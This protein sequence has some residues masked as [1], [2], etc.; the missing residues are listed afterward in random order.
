MTTSSSDVPRAPRHAAGTP[1]RGNALVIS[2]GLLA[3]IAVAV[4]VS[5]DEALS[6]HGETFRRNH[7]NASLAAVDA[8]LSKREGM[9]IQDAED[10]RLRTWT[11]GVA[12]DTNEALPECRNNFG[13]D[14]VGQCAVLWKIEP[15]RSPDNS[16]ADNSGTTIPFVQNPSPLRTYVA[17]APEVINDFSFFYRISAEA[18]V[19]PNDDGALPLGR[20]QGERML[21]ITGEPLF[22]Y[23]IFYAKDGVK[24]DLELSHGFSLNVRGGVYSNGAIYIGGGTSLTWDSLAPGNQPT[25]LGPDTTGRTVRVVGV[26]GI[27]RLSK[28][29]MYSAFNFL[30]KM[31]GSNPGFS[32]A[33]AYD[34]AIT[35]PERSDPPGLLGPPATVAEATLDGNHINPYRVRNQSR[36]YTRSGVSNRRFINN[37]EITSDI[38]GGAIGNDSRDLHRDADETWSATSLATWNRRALTRVTNARKQSLPESMRGRPLEPQ[39]LVYGTD[40]GVGATDDPTDDHDE[41]LEATPMFVNAATGQRVPFSLAGPVPHIEVPGTYLTNAMGDRNAHFVRKSAPFNGWQ[42]RQLGDLATAAPAATQ[43]GLIIRERPVPDFSY[44]MS[45][46]VTDLSPANETHRAYVP[47]AYGKHK[48]PYLW[49]FTPMFV[50]DRGTT[51]AT[52]NAVLADVNNSGADGSEAVTNQEYFFGGHVRVRCANNATA[53]GSSPSPHDQDGYHRTNMRVIHLKAPV[54]P[55]PAS[56]DYPSVRNLGAASAYFAK[57]DFVAVQTRISSI[58]GG[59]PNP[60][61]RGRKAG[62]MIMPLDATTLGQ[63]GIHEYDK[64]L[65]S[66]RPYAAIFYSPERGFFTQRRFEHSRVGDVSDYFTNTFDT[67]DPSNDGFAW[68]PAATVYR[69]SPIDTKYDGGIEDPFGRSGSPPGSVTIDTGE[70]VYTFRTGGYTRLI[71]QRARQRRQAAEFNVTLS[72]AAPGSFVPSDATANP[73][74]SIGFYMLGWDQ[75]SAAAPEMHWARI[76]GYIS[77]TTVKVR[78]EKNPAEAYTYGPT[79]AASYTRP[80]DA[81]TVVKWERDPWGNLVQSGQWAAAVAAA[82]GDEQRV[83]DAIRDTEVPLSTPLGYYDVDLNQPPE[84]APSVVWPTLSGFTSSE[85]P[86]IGVSPTDPDAKTFVVPRS[87]QVDVNSYIS[88]RGA[89]YAPAPI[90]TADYPS[91]CDTPL[92][93][94]TNVPQVLPYLPV[95]ATIY[96]ET[97]S[98]RPDLYVGVGSGD[99]TAP[100]FATPTSTSVVGDPWED[101][102]IARWSSGATYNPDDTI[103]C[104]SR[105]FTCTAAH[106]ADAARRPGTGLTW[107]TAWQ[108]AGLWLRIEKITDGSHQYLRFL[109]YA[110][111][112]STPTAAQFIEMTDGQ[113]NLSRA[114]VTGWES[115]WVVGLASQSGQADWPMSATYSNI[116]IETALPAPL[117]VIDCID[118]E[119]RVDLAKPNEWARYMA[120]QYQVFWGTREITEHFFNYKQ[121]EAPEERLVTEGWMYNTREFWSQPRWW[122]QTDRDPLTGNPVPRAQW[123]EKETG[124]AVAVDRTTNRNNTYWRRMMARS[125]FLDVNLEKV[126]QYMQATTVAQATADSWGWGTPAMDPV[127]WNVPL[128]STF[129]GLIYVARAN[130]Y[131]W[132]PVPVNTGVVPVIAGQHPLQAV[133]NPFNP[134][135]PNIANTALCNSTSLSSTTNSD[136]VFSLGSGGPLGNAITGNAHALPIRPFDFHHGVMISNASRL[137][138]GGSAVWNNSRLTIVTPNQLYLNGDINSVMANDGSGPRV[139]P[140]AVM[141]DTVTLLSNSWSMAAFQ[142]DGLRLTDGGIDWGFGRG[143]LGG[144]FAELGWN[145]PNY[146]ASPTRYNTCIV[147]NNQPT[148]RDRVRMG[149]GASVVNALQLLESWD[150]RPLDYLGSLVVLD[151]ARYT[152]SF[153]LEQEKWAGR[154]ALGV[155]GWNADFAEFNGG[156]AFAAADRDWQGPL[157]RV[158]T[159]PTRNLSFNN[160]LLLQAGTP[161]FAPFSFTV[162]GIASWSRPIQ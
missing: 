6:V 48:R 63:A 55:I 24:G 85:I 1:R 151:T 138:W 105:L 103:Q 82:G 112:A 133:Q 162:N 78:W 68:P 9:L 40:A 128:A 141:G 124:L 120:S 19:Q 33:S 111:L 30:G 75:P 157:P 32:L 57:D 137:F 46:T 79:A 114:R 56:A 150:N 88:Q 149:E 72:D 148:T 123:I 156:A 146:R 144:C 160:D 116:R 18:R 104:D 110:G 39:A 115:D 20:A 44:I 36:L 153:L 66:R 16:A 49:P 139:V 87:V 62:L 21:S 100:T 145:N 99:F 92:A 107:M 41:H 28:P 86:N 154:G 35:P 3:L 80:G 91:S 108:P 27:F 70:G 113:G 76:I 143:T 12:T 15:V 126:Q 60:G 5:T 102:P 131:P 43:A 64:G 95:R 17:T 8:V 50:T 42:I 94:L 67:V 127:T 51:P 159:P 11:G 14:Y 125:T 69:S 23:A 152:R 73:A 158:Y 83:I 121:D 130:R 132:N 77:P 119:N 101:S 74:R 71:Q 37:I 142:R 122:N 34:L 10:D 31:G 106:S 147:T 25:N 134:E 22:R 13:V 58:S 53:N 52:Y 38:D 84:P 93:D 109:Y 96:P 90:G 129:S 2:L 118:W 135:L 97:G 4:T 26:D 59:L 61:P 29:V 155:I 81:R 89:W 45:A 161:P 7:H 98:F 54:Q 136:L 140:M 65:N 47:F 117:E